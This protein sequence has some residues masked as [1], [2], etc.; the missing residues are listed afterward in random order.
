MFTK[1]LSRAPGYILV[2]SFFPAI[3]WSYLHGLSHT[4]LKKIETTIRW[5]F[6]MITDEHQDC[7]FFAVSITIK[8]SS[9]NIS[10]MLTQILP[11]LHEHQ[12]GYWRK[13]LPW[14]ILEEQFPVLRNTAKSKKV[15]APLHC[16]D[17]SNVIATL[18]ITNFH[19]YL[20]QLWW[21]FFQIF[22]YGD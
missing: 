11:K 13:R 9:Q 6:L 10:I 20:I 3:S 22:V 8:T 1:P 17:N 12:G 19:L 18:I 21:Q 16:Y 5:N 2:K 7:T 4:F 15:K 14:T